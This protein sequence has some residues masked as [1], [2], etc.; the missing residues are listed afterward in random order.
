MSD[1]AV[2]ELVLSVGKCYP[3][4]NTS[5]DSFR[6]EWDDAAGLVLFAMYN[7]IND[8][9]KEQFSAQNDLVVRYTV[10]GDVCY[11]VFRFGATP[12]AD[13]PFLPSLYRNAGRTFALPDI[14]CGKGLTLTVLLIDSNTGELC[15]IRLIGLGHDFSVK[16]RDWAQNAAERLMDFAEYNRRVEAV[17]GAYSSVDLAL[18]GFSEGNQYV[19]ETTQ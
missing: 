10:I 8:W 14:E 13:C 12:W 2:Q 18:R 7:G 15:G 3:Q 11:F 9:E 1:N 16:W 4:W 19:V 17:Y 6:L 5:Q